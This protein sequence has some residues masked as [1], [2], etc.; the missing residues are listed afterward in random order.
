MCRPIAEL[1]ILKQ[2][3]KQAEGYMESVVMKIETYSGKYDDEI[4]ALILKI[5]NNEAKINLSLEEQP[6]L[7]NIKSYYQ[8]SGGEFWI[9]RSNDKVIGTLGLILRENNCAVM[10]K[11]FVD[12]A[13]RSQKV[14]LALYKKLLA[15][16]ILMEVH[17]IILD[18]PSVATA[19]HKFYENAGFYK[20]DLEHLHIPYKYPDHNSILY[21]LDL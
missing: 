19:S 11:F 15:F 7:K 10:K 13:Y 18:T 8:G 12:S 20:T 9:A 2:L 3:I 4:I 21:V 6:D 16:A 1:V 14:G 17:H 5:Q